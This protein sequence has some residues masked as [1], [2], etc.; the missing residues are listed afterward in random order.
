MHKVKHNVAG[1][2]VC[3][4]YYVLPRASDMIYHQRAQN[5]T[6][7][8]HRHASELPKQICNNFVR[9]YCKNGGHCKYYSHVIQMEETN[10][11]TSDL[12]NGS[13]GCF[14]KDF[15]NPFKR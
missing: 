12:P 9:G 2:N 1:L 7:I 10:S 11:N 15:I 5:E 8:C 3:A 4:H 14:E 13:V 6:Y